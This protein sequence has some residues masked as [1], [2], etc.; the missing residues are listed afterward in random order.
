M[1]NEQHVEITIR[2]AIASRLGAVDYHLMDRF[3]VLLY[4]SLAVTL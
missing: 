4:E 1:D 2:V 3:G